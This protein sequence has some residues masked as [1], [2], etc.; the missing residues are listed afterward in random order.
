MIS[1]TKKAPQ[2]AVVTHRN[3]LESCLLVGAILGSWVPVIAVLLVIAK[4]C[5]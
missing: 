4:G 5:R 2:W 1:R 3:V